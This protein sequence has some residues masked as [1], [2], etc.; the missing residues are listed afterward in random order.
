MRIWEANASGTLKHTRNNAH[1][2]MAMLMELL[3]D[4]L[5]VKVK[6]DERFPSL[7]AGGI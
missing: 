4:N 6:D 7:K 3:R 5:K 2:M 1:K